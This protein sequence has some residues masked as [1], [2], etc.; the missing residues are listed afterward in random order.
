RA[1][2][3][4]AE[5]VK[6][7][8]D[9]RISLNEPGQAREPAALQMWTERF[10]TQTGYFDELRR[11]EK[12]PENAENRAM[13]LKEIVASMD[14]PNA[15]GTLPHDRLQRFLENVT[16][17]AERQEEADAPSDQVT[18]ITMHSC[19]G[20]EF[21]HVY[22]VGMEDGLLPHS[23]SKLE[24]TLDEERRLFYVAVTRAQERLSLTHCRGRKKYGQLM[25]CHPS[26]FL[27]E[28]PEELVEH[29]SEREAN[30]VSAETGKSLF[31]AMREAIG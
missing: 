5:F 11:V 12:D 18:L 13:N 31:A 21:P 8:N 2:Q 6:F 9:T 14:G 28:I 22:V 20:L 23:R 26:P 25:P 3:A 29:A 1:Q 4:V 17:D 10:L 16:L 24:G 7:V 15:V 19:K 30:P 27:K